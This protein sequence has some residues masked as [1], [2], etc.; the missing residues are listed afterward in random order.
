MVQISVFSHII[1][2]QE[3][4]IYSAVSSQYQLISYRLDAVIH[5]RMYMAATPF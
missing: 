1:C 3:I 2:I 4:Q 5:V